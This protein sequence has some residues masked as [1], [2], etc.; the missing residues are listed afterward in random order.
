MI[1]QICGGGCC[2]HVSLLSRIGPRHRII[3]QGTAAH[4]IVCFYGTIFF[5]FL[6]RIFQN[7]KFMV[8]GLVKQLGNSVIE[9]ELEGFGSGR[10]NSLS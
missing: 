6:I 3:Y 4:G 7:P 1:R 8:G 10:D 9:E 5:F 2:V